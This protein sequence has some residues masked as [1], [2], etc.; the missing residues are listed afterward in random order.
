MTDNPLWRLNDAGQSIWLDFID[1]KMLRNG[2][3]ERR[4]KND[5]LS[6][7]TSNPTIFQKAI[8][9]TDLYDEDI[10]RFA[11]AGDPTPRIFERLAVED[12]RRAATRRQVRGE[13][14]REDLVRPGRLPVR[15]RLEH[16][17]EPSL[18][19]TRSIPRAVE[20]DECP[21]AIV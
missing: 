10:R 18:W 9:E 11:Q 16:D 6:G 4:I 15:E 2:D 1:R 5:A 7:M 13:P 8:A 17:V 20:R 14:V 12:V 3:L 21:V 19:L